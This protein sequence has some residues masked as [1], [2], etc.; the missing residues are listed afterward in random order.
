[1]GLC[2]ERARA[3][4]IHNGQYIG[5]QWLPQH[6]R[7]QWLYVMSH[8]ASQVELPLQLVVQ[9]RHVLRQLSQ[10]G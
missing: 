3:P 4:G 5:G 2:A 8:E 6:A 10:Q 7:M 1:M 9:V